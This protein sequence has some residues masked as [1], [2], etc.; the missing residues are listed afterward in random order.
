MACIPNT[1]HRSHLCAAQESRVGLGY[2]SPRV[3][4]WEIF[5]GSVRTKES[6]RAFFISVTSLPLDGLSENDLISHRQAML[7]TG[8]FTSTLGFSPI[9]PSCF[10]SSVQTREVSVKS[11][12][13]WTR[14][15]RLALRW[16]PVGYFIRIHDHWRKTDMN[17][18][19]S[20]EIGAVR[21]LVPTSTLWMMAPVSEWHNWL[22]VSALRVRNKQLNCF[23]FWA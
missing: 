20:L 16:R 12:R 2:P 1:G 22:S 15:V 11:R 10:A 3:S 23:F 5:V 13:I 4:L 14:V 17:S 18:H 7:P 19:L 9:E 6:S 21:Q 8:V